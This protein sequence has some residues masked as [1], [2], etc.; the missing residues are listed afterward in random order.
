MVAALIVAPSNNLVTAA[1]DLPPV[2]PA[3]VKGDI[4]VAGSGT[5]HPLTQKLADAFKSAGYSGK[6]T[7]ESTSTGKGIEAFCDGKIDIANASRAMTDDEIAT[8]KANGREPVQ[9]QVG[10]DA[11]VIAVSRQNRFINGLTKDQVGQI[12][13][14]KAQ[15]WKDVNEKWPA[16]KIA[17][18]SPGPTHGTYDFFSESIFTSETDATAR[19]KIV[20]Q[21]PGVQLLEDYRQIA[22]RV[23]KDN[24]AVG[25]FGYGFYSANRAKLRVV[26]LDNVTANDKTMAAN[27]YALSRPLFIVTSAKL[28]KDKPQVAAFVNFYL[29]TVN[30]VI[31]E[32]GYFPESAEQL[33]DMKS[34]FVKAINIK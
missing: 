13:S 8:C 32:V 27:Q 24:F 29:I 14:G 16:Q 18:F 33:N 34:A 20:Q 11:L 21:V 25:Y 7:V 3:E 30:D 12:F 5:V 17:L 6:L 31:S 2:K 28:L 1:T 10:T 4:S 26:T 19:K 23:N 22:N 15:T 9:F